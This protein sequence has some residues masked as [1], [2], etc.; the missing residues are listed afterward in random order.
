MAKQKYECFKLHYDN[1]YVVEWHCIKK[2]AAPK[3]PDTS[4]KN[5][6][7]Y[8]TSNNR[9]IAITFDN[10]AID[11][12]KAMDAY[13]L[14]SMLVE[15]ITLTEFENAKKNFDKE[16]SEHVDDIFEKKGGDNG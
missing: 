10:G 11:F 1:G 3:K 14:K 5:G 13:R 9:L 4:I 12:Y 16:L 7:V 15:E 2:F 8:T 6:L